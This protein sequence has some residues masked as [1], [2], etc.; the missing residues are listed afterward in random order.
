LQEEIMKA[1]VVAAGILA[2]LGSAAPTLA[3]SKPTVV[4]IVKESASPYWQSVL[5]GARKAG[6]ELGIALSEFGTQSG[7]DVNAQIGL[8]QM[9]VASN[10]AAILIAPMQSTAFQMP[11]EE[12]AKKT[13][14]VSLG[15]AADGASA[16]PRVGTDNMKAGG[17]AADGLA[18]A[19]TRTYGDTEGNVA[20][21]TSRPSV[22]SLDQRTK[23]FK[24]VVAAKY[25]A[26]D[27]V[28]DKVADGEPAT[29]RRIVKELVAGTPD[30]RGI[31]VADTIMTP[32]VWQGVLD[33]KASDKINIVGFGASA[34]LV[35][36]MQA[37]V[38]AGLVLEDPFRIGYE[39]VRSAL[40]AAHG[41]SVKP[42]VDTGVTLITKATMNS[43][44]S[45]ELLASNMH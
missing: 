33:G 39:G 23:G 5:A 26:L 4:I 15:S 44:R 24:D 21:I 41:E 36:L 30:L 12:G 34:E 13:K 35:K 10:P 25:R 43:P 17:I 18:A 31:L 6:Q 22:R 37:D 11:I 45:Q 29:V 7:S 38:I 16:I 40:A 28:A 9:A 19:I 14:I 20:I 2:G 8:L 42:R 32:V 3:Q 27:I 1:L